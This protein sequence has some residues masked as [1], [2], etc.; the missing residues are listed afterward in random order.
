MRSPSLRSGLQATLMTATS[1]VAPLPRRGRHEHSFGSSLSWQSKANEFSSTKFLR[2][3]EI[4]CSKSH[5]AIRHE[6]GYPAG[7]FS[8][9]PRIE[10]SN[11]NSSVRPRRCWQWPLTPS[12]RGDND[13]FTFAAKGAVRTSLHRRA[14]KFALNWYAVSIQG[15]TGKVFQDKAPTHWF[16]A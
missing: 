13:T 4:A 6:L 1:S 2:R 12:I 11:P 14:R 7:R 15:R 8:Y 5:S 9:P 10:P 16:G 3:S